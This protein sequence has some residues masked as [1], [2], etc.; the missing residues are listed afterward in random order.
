MPSF[1]VRTATTQYEA[2]V[3]SNII[4]KLA[5]FLPS[6]VSQIFV[7]TT[8]D[9]WSY[10]SRPLESVLEG[11]KHKVLFFPGGE[12]NK[13]MSEVEALADQMVGAGAD[14]ASLVI[15]FGGGIVTDVAGFLAAIFLRGIPV[16]QIPTTLLGQVDAA[17]GGKTG[18]NLVS[19]KNLIGSFHQPLAV[20]IDPEVLRTL[21]ER[22][23]RA[24]LYEVL[25]AGVIRSKELFDLMALRSADVLGQHPDVLAQI[26]SESVRIKCEVVTADEK[27]GDLRRILNFGHTI[28][29]ALEAES[30]YLRVLHGEAVSFG[31]TAATHLARLAGHL[32]EDDANAILKCIEIYG[33]IPSLEGIN[34]ESLLARLGSDKKTLHGKVHFVLPTKIGE[35]II[36]NN[37]DPE[38]IRQ[39]TIAALHVNS[40]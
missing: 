17:V 39:A 6:K 22:E 40:R 13:R 21:P 26:I 34:A 9:V 28:G 20:L 24:G 5:S 2:I 29:H 1:T 11:R 36:T 12:S 18:V 38:L 19:G 33:P 4:S 23:Y 37:V 35:V 14:R 31:M 8:P 27:E 16:L 7:V 30:S 10:H 3:E 25:K 32:N 15:G